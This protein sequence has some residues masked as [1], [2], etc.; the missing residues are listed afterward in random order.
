M[1]LL[2]VYIVKNNNYQVLNEM[3]YYITL[4]RLLNKL[5]LKIR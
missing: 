5:E 2:L 4:A 1:Y 3:H